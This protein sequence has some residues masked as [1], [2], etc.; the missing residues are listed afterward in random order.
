MVLHNK[1]IFCVINPVDKLFRGFTQGFCVCLIISEGGH[2]KNV[3][4]AVVK[5]RIAG[6][7][8]ASEPDFSFSSVR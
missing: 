6:K 2:I 4:L 3:F 7:N 1:I 5:L 8:I